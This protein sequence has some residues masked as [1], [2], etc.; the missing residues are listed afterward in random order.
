VSNKALT[1]AFA[2]RTGNPGRKAVLVA[3]ADMADEAHS[4]WPDQGTLAEM[5]D[6]SERSVRGHLAEL[7]RRGLIA[8]AKRYSKSGERTS[9]RYTLPVSVLASVVAPPAELPAESA[10]GLPAEPAASVSSLPARNV[11]TTGR[12]RRV[13]LKNPQETPTVSRGAS[14]GTR[15]DPSWLRT[16][17]DRAWQAE[18]DIPDDFAREATAEFKDHFIA[19]SGANATKRDWSAAWRNWMRRAWRERH[20]EA[21]RKRIGAPVRV[22]DWDAE[23]AKLKAERQRL[24]FRSTDAL[25]SAR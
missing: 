16:E 19:A 20:G 7:E 14:K 5:T 18:H 11:A 22:V 23:R 21:Y 9:D 17:G 12:I 6:Q 2:Q 4:C 1:W 10:A 13:T 15:L 24:A 8:R 3:L 25:A